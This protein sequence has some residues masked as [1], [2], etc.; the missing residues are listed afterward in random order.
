VSGNTIGDVERVDLIIHQDSDC[1]FEFEWRDEDNAP[2]PI[3]DAE[4]YVWAAEEELHADLTPFITIGTGGNTHIA[5]VFVPAVDTIEI[6]PL[7]RGAWEFYANS[8]AGTRKKLGRGSAWVM[9]K[10]G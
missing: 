10:K 1:E 3:A 8:V 9:R 4:C 6:L 5:A 2:V 7:V